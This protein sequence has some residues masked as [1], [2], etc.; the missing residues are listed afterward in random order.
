MD[1][2]FLPVGATTRIARIV[3]VNAVSRDPYHLLSGWISSMTGRLSTRTA[4]ILPSLFTHYHRSQSDLCPCL[5][6]VSHPA[7]YS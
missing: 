2:T 7:A 1:T 3:L 4:H 6:Y 5:I